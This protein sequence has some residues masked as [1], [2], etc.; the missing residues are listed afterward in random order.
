MVMENVQKRG[1][2]QRGDGHGLLVYHVDYPYTS[3][4]MTDSPNNNPG[5]PSVAVVPSGGLMISSYLRG[6]GKQYTRN[7]WQESLQAVPFPGTKEVTSLTDE[8]QLPNYC[9]WNG[10][11]VKKTGFMLSSIS[12]DTET[13]TVSFVVS[14]DDPSGVGEIEIMRNIEGATSV[15][16]LQGRRIYGNLKSGIYIIDGKKR[17][18]K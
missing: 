14:P 4:N 8:M 18:V 6:T 16:D 2:N 9:F 3:V 17:F 12:E 11:T 15:Y 1:L 7:Q 10:K 5:H 13:G